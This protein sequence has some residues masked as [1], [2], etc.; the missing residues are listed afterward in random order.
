MNRDK[1]RLIIILAT[2]LILVFFLILEQWMAAVMPGRG[3]RVAVWLIAAIMGLLLLLWVCLIVFLRIE[4][5]AKEKEIAQVLQAVE[6][7][8]NRS[9]S[10]F[11]S[12]VTY[13][14]RTPINAILGMNEMILREAEKE[15]VRSYARN[16]RHS[17]QLILS[18]INDVLDYSKLESGDIEIDEHEYRLH[19]LVDDV[20]GIIK[21]EAEQK[22]LLFLSRVDR[23]LPDTLYGA[24]GRIRQ[25]IV[26]LLKNA[27]KFTKEGKI[28]FVV[29]GTE[30]KENNVVEL[31]FK[32]TD[33]GI[34]IRRADLPDLFKSFHR[35]D[36]IN[37]KGEGAG[38]GLSISQNLVQRMN[39]RIDVEST[40]GEGSEFTVYLPQKI[41]GA[42]EKR[43]LRGN[44]E[45][46]TGG[47]VSGEYIVAEG[48]EILLVD[49][50]EVN[51]FVVQNLLERSRACVTICSSGK[52]CLKMMQRKHYDLIFL[53]HMMP[54]LDGIETV[55]IAQEMRNNKCS[56]TPV[57]A[58]TANAVMGAKETYLKEGF[59][60]YLSKP[61][62]SAQLEE[63]LRK[64]LPKEVQRIEKTPEALEHERRQN[65]ESGQGGAKSGKGYHSD[66]AVIEIVPSVNQKKSGVATGGNA[67]K[68]L[69]LLDFATG[70]E[71]SG[72]DEEM[73]HEFLAM[74]C[75]VMQKN[76]GRIQKCFDESDCKQYV[77]LVH[78]LK[79]SSLTIGAVKLSEAAKTL[80]LEGKKFLETAHEG[81]PDYIISHHA[82]VME[83]YEKSCEEGQKWLA[84]NSAGE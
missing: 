34:G 46:R 62:N 22:E 61:V 58:L 44:R 43:L 4:N 84:E 70:I 17:S 66:M 71:Y 24:E 29:S 36:F 28:M 1:R 75:D 67:E 52:E 72:G 56:G 18:L 26:H 64:Y 3:R 15:S 6:E 11:L 82:E 21:P 81:M 65:R 78:A 42:Q 39:G 49:D 27:V 45:G 73:Y 31:K 38:L 59:R 32:V 51:L 76:K 83:L 16:I 74:F 69:S 8:A 10:E 20:I 54:E 12:N 79:S 80:E 37:P 48:A 77:T 40:Y 14:I 13:E 68:P 23:D 33:T 5:R 53:D 55:Q 35:T 9:K 41:V 60:D 19:S 7:K 63:I 47:L 2:I 25:I 50:N 57:I 30:D